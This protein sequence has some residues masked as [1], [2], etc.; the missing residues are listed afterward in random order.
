MFPNPIRGTLVAD[1]K[2]VISAKMGDG[3]ITKVVLPKP[4]K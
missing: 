4:G 3:D 2:P 1:T